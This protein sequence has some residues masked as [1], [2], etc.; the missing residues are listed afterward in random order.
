MLIRS[1]FDCQFHVEKVNGEK[2]KTSYC[3]RE[4]C[5]SRFSKCIAMKALERYLEEECSPTARSA[6]TGNVVTMA[7]V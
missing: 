3:S 6:S 1:C 7:K 4:N 2:E 5:F